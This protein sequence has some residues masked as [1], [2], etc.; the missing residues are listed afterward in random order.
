[1]DGGWEILHALS[2]RIQF[3]GAFGRFK[4]DLIWKAHAENKCKFFAW[5]LIQDKILTA[6]NLASRDWPHHDTCTL[7]NGPLETSQHLCLLCPFAQSVWQQVLAW[8]NHN[9]GQL[10][11]PDRFPSISAWWERAAMN[12]QKDKLHDFNGAAIYIMWN[13][14]K[15]R[16]RRIFEDKSQTAQQ[17]AAQTKEDSEHWRRAFRTPG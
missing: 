13:I 9:L 15:E 4:S 16:N 5:T 17:I 3:K 7:C 12:I 10:G 8:E 14:W 6:D 2:Y 11:S 1:M